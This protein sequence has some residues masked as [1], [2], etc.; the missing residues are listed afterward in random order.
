[1]KAVGIKL[2]LKMVEEK[3]ISSREGEQMIRSFD[4]IQSII[5][6]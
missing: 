5:H 6:Y 4:R 1:M 2:V 3:K